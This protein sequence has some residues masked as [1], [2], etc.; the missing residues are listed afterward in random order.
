MDYL[1]KTF[2]TSYDVSSF[3][4]YSILQENLNPKG[5]AIS[6]IGF[7]DVSNFPKLQNFQFSRLGTSLIPSL[8]IYLV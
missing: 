7:L 2:Y 6:I 1:L 5:R 3:M 4:K 8:Y